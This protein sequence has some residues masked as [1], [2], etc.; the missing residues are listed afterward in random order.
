MTRSIAV[1]VMSGTGC[2]GFPPDALATLDRSGRAASGRELETARRGAIMRGPALG[3]AMPPSRSW[4]ASGRVALWLWPGP[5]SSSWSRDTSRPAR[6]PYPGPGAGD[7]R[8]PQRS[9]RRG[10]R[11]G[12]P[13]G[14]DGATGERAARPWH[15]SP[16]T[17]ASPRP[18][19]LARDAG[20]RPALPR[21]AG[22]WG[23]AH[24]R[25]PPTWPARRARHR[26][27]RR[28][29]RRSPGPRV[30]VPGPGPARRGAA[31]RSRIPASPTTAG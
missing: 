4:A 31:S 26:R 18:R 2:D 9:A 28:R 25:S 14:R 19:C 27:T 11:S 1:Q 17:L 23:A 16:G 30:A 10:R 21:A 22:A 5:T 15:C 7:R 3:A 13:A 29:S 8:R 24:T 12:R 6:H 20:Q